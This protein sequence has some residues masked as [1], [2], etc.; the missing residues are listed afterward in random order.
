MSSTT[1]HDPERTLL[2][3]VVLLQQVI[4]ELLIRQDAVGYPQ[5]RE[6]LAS[7]EN[8]LAQGAGLAPDLLRP[9]RS[10]IDVMD[11]LH[12]PL[13]P[14]E[15]PRAPDWLDHLRRNGFL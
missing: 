3:G 2:A 9:L 12:R 14:G 15:R 6:F 13:G 5:A 8:R 10:A 7:V 4:L 11:E 1:P